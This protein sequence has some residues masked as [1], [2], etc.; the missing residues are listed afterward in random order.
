M[1]KP[2]P[3]WPRALARMSLALAWSTGAC[4]ASQS[5]LTLSSTCPSSSSAGAEVS[6][7]YTVGNNGP[8]GVTGS[9]NFTVQWTLAAG[10]T[11]VRTDSPSSW[12]CSVSGLTVTCTAKSGL[13]VGQT[14][15]LV[16]VATA[17]AAAG[18]Y[19]VSASVLP[20]AGSGI[21]DPVTANDAQ[22]CSTSNGGTS[23]PPAAFDAFDTS[24]AA[25]ST[26]GR[27]FTQIAGSGF[28]I[29]VVALASGGS[30]ASGFSGTVKVELLDANDNSGSLNT[31]TN[32][33]STW[34]SVLATTT[35]N[36]TSGGGGRTT[37][38]FSLGGNVWPD[39]R[40]RVSYPATGTASVIACSGDNFALLPATLSV[41]ALDSDFSSPAPASGGRVLANT[42][43]SGGN[44]HKAG[45][46][47]TL[48]VTARDAN[49]VATPNYS[50]T[51]Y[52]RSAPVA[53]VGSVLLPAGGV[54]GSVSAGSFAAGSGGIWRSDNATYFEVGAISMT[55]VDDNFAAVDGG[56]G[57]PLAARRAQGS[58][59]VGR[60]VPDHFALALA[61]TPSFATFNDSGCGTRSFTYIGQPFGYALAPAYTVTAQAVGNTTTVN[62]SGS[63]WKL[64]TASATAD[65]T[66][67][68]NQCQVTAGSVSATYTYSTST[69]ATP[70]WDAN[71]SQFAAPSLIANN[72]G[73][74]S[75]VL[76]ADKLSFKRSTTTPIVPFTAT[77]SITAALLDFSEKNLSGNGSVLTTSGNTPNA[78]AFDAGAE[79]RYGRLK[80]S[81]AYGSELYDLPIA[82]ETQYWNGSGFVTNG[83]DFCTQIPAASF[84][85]SGYTGAL[86]ACRTVPLAGNRFAAGKGSL[87]LLKP[88]SGNTGSVLVTPGLNASAGQTCPAQGAAS[89]QATASNAAAAWLLGRWVGSAY[90]QNPSARAVFGIYKNSDKLIQMR[91]NY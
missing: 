33:R 15:N 86:A 55:L 70:N 65:C 77:V 71:L 91:E 63:L 3:I 41:Q 56:D 87:R 76:G 18:S 20:A 19:S 67:N 59:A 62:Y 5:D 80:L 28:N 1:S 40:V 36:F 73:T 49:G 32:C 75:L 57:T 30:L 4:A 64:A 47:F 69:G 88:G 24:Y 85:L 46:P 42:A 78:I 44:V 26:S 12:D 48:I 74:G 52:R 10:M 54:A 66:T 84:A 51:P 21:T 35:A 37:T 83:A 58:A 29:A 9:G 79:F 23:P 13:P 68:P 17:P 16:L 7:T 2:A 50:A 90:D 34:S 53:S 6:Y 61:D 43:V 8:S 11:F 38:S 81:N 25:G 72:N 39:L 31:S 82:M 45:Q 27:L 14:R 89:L 22:N 60:F